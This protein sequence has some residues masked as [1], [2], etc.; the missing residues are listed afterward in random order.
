MDVMFRFTYTPNHGESWW[1]E[2]TSDVQAARLFERK[3]LEHY[4]APSL[5]TNGTEKDSLMLRAGMAIV[6][7][8]IQSNSVG[9]GNGTLIFSVIY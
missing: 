7:S 2:G 5:H 3:Y 8:R 6:S 1:V 4:V 9:I